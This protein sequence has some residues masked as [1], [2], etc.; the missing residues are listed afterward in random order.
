MAVRT[1]GT[2]LRHDGLTV[3][4]PVAAISLP[5]SQ[6]N[7]SQL[8]NA[9]FVC[10]TFYPITLFGRHIPIFVHYNTIRVMSEN[11]VGSSHEERR[12]KPFQDIGTVYVNCWCGEVRI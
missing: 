5:H 2:S 7:T 6:V 3:L 8:R 12:V 11:H 9:V 10:P 4:S 1:P